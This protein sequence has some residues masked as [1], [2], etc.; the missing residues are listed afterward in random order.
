MKKALLAF[1]GGLDTSA[2]LIWLQKELNYEVYCYCCDLG[3]QPDESWLREKAISL[4]AKEFIFEDVKELFAKEF[5][6]KIVRNGALYEGEYLL[7]TAIGRPLIAQRMGKIAEK[8]DI[9]TFVHGATGK[10]NDQLR[11]EQS[12]AY[13]YPEKKV[14][15]PW[16]TWDFKG[17]SDLIQYLADAGFPYQGESGGKYSID[18]NLFHKSTEGC[19]LEHVEGPYDWENIVGNVENIE[20]LALKLTF[21]NGFA[22]QLNGENLTADMMIEKLNIFGEKFGIGIVDIVEER[23]NGIKSRGIYQTPGGTILS[24][25][26]KKLKEICWTHKITKISQM[27]GIEYAE[28]VYDGSWFSSARE[29]IDSYFDKACESLNGEVELELSKNFIK[30][31]S[32]KSK[33]SL[34]SQKLVSFEE[35]EFAI[36]KYAIGFCQ[37]RNLIFKNEGRVK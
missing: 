1:S 35:D 18:E 14:L 37:T 13:L 10:G 31:L 2:I 11:L 29:A 36:N 6:M 30:V 21:V 27:M 22:V 17:R 12:W 5:A 15:T 9:D 24:L 28:L 25:G 20:P 23:V 34:Y 7:G 3:N 32:R 19:E 26:L 33:Q 16:K 4:G 8:Y